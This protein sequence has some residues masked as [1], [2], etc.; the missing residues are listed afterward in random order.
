MTLE[1]LLS[2]TTQQQF[3]LPIREDWQTPKRQPPWA[4]QHDFGEP[5][6]PNQMDMGDMGWLQQLLYALLGYQDTP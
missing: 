5:M 4:P 3:S 1:E 2:G 6:P